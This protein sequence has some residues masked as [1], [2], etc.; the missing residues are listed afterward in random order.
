MQVDLL[1]PKDSKDPPVSR[2]SLVRLAPQVPEDPLDL[3][4]RVV[5]MVTL[6]SQ[7]GLV[8]EELSDPRALE[9]SP[10]LPVCLDSRESGGTMVLM[11]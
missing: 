3:L 4:E 8:R 11:D 5:K 2:E 7:E 6:E 1:V 9:A 10:G